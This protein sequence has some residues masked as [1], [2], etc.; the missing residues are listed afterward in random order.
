MWRVIP[1][2]AKWVLH[3][4][5][6]T[7][8]LI[9]HMTN[10][11]TSI[12]YLRTKLHRPLIPRDHVHRPRLLEHLD[13]RRERP[14]TLVSAPAGYGKSIL[15]SSWLETS[16]S[17]GAWLSLDEQDNDLRQ[18]LFGFL[19]AVQSI[20]P[21]AVREAQA[22]VSAP[23][24]PPLQVLSTVLINDLDRI[25]E[26]FILVLDDFH[27][28]HDE[29]VHAFLREALRHPPQPMHLVLISRKDPFLPIST[30]R[31]RDQV[32]EVR[33]HDLRFSPEEAASYLRTALGDLMDEAS[34]ATLTEKTEGWITGLRLAV[35]S[36]RHQPDAGAKMLEMAANSSYVMDYF[37]EEVLEGQAPEIRRYLLST[38]I[39]DRFCAS[40]CDALCA[41]GVEGKVSEIDG[42]GFIT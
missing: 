28:I 16:D 20:F 25:E 13:Q 8:V 33:T 11:S 29:S 40:L 31:A 41:P 22:M 23:N 39:P 9:T 26:D 3:L 24:L 10:D 38:A 4:S 42:Q 7:S 6:Q 37:F 2:S 32:T 21:E 34:A 27:F 1:S 15:T 18:F 30:L 12:P 14:L 36:L 17:P 35:L 5:F 19:A